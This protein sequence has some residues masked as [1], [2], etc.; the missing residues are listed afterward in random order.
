MTTTASGSSMSGPASCRVASMPSS[1]GMRTSNRQTSGLQ[2]AGEGD[3]LSAV[4]G[5][6]HDLD[7][8]LGVEDHPQ[9]GADD[10]L[11]V[12]DDHADHAPFLGSVAVTSQPPP[13]LGPAS[14]VPPSRAARSVMPATPY[15]GARRGGRLAVVE[16]DDEHAVLLADDA[17]VDPGRVSRVPDRVGDRLLGDPVDGGSDHRPQAVEVAHELDVHARPV[18]S[19]GEPGDVGDATLRR[20]VRIV[21]VAQRPRRWRAA[22]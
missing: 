7:A 2:R 10:L 8:G 17:D 3:G 18:G 12:G 20:E 19:R 22:P 21:A 9:A 1:S 15:P 5:L 14:S 4:G 11:V 16:H 6:A 13:G